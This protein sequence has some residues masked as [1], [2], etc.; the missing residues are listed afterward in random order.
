MSKGLFVMKNSKC[1]S[2]TSH[3]CMQEIFKLR[4]EQTD[5]QFARQIVRQTDRQKKNRRIERQTVM[6]IILLPCS[7]PTGLQEVSLS[8]KDSVS[9][10]E[11]LVKCHK[12]AQKRG[13]VVQWSSSLEGQSIGVKKAAA[14]IKHCLCFL[15]KSK[16]YQTHI[17][18]TKKVLKRAS[19][20]NL[21]G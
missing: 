5:S 18:L 2:K 14:I 21:K 11:A 13:L 15:V 1:C 10:K 17:K 20:W 3:Y 16:N 12:L 19:K 9:L 7:K 8:Q 4:E 6:Q